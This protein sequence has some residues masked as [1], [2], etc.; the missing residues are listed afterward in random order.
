M[1]E[2]K[3]LAGIGFC[4]I[5][6]FLFFVMCGLKGAGG[7]ILCIFVLTLMAGFFASQG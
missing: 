6:A 4:S 1:P 3:D 5:I 7:L 2:F